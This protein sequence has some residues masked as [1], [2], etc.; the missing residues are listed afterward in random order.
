MLAAREVVEVPD[1]EALIPLAVQRQ[2]ALHLGHGRP[3]GGGRP[4]PA[5]VELVEAIPLELQPQPPNAAGTAP[6][7]LGGLDP[8]QLPRQGLQ[9]HI[10][11]FHG[12]LHRAQRIDHGHPLGCHCGHWGE[13]E[14]SFHVSKAATSRIPY[15]RRI[16]S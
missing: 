12:A 13:L 10:A 6:Q 15:T 8:R 16:S 3:F 1:V 4:A 14:R 5:V 11:D 9:D 2:E 7:D